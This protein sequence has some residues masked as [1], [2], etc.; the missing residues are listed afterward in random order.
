[1][2]NKRAV[3]LLAI[4]MCTLPTMA[5]V[6]RYKYRQGETVKILSQVE[7]DVYVNRV[8]S[9]HALI[10]NRV[11][12]EITHMEGTTATHNATFMVSENST[13]NTIEI[14][15][16][17]KEY[18]SVF[19]RD[20]LGHYT[21]DKSYFMPVVR[22]I[23]VFPE[24]DIQVGD[25]WTA[26]GHEAHDLR[27]GFNVPEP[28]IVPFAAQYTYVGTAEEDGK[29]LH[30]IDV[31][32]NI[33]FASPNLQE[34][35]R[36][37]TDVPATTMGYSHQRIY[38]DNERGNIAWYNEEFRILIE[39]AYGNTFDF[40]GTAYAEVDYLQEKASTKVA[41][42]QDTI[43][44]LGLENT[45]VR[46]DEEGLTISIENI[47]FMPD[48]AI[49]LD[50]EKAKLREIAKVIQQFPLNDLLISG[51]TALAGTER[52]RQS[53]SEERAHAVA[54]Y[55]A[56]IG[57]K[58]STHIFTRGFGATKPIAPNNTEEGKAKNRRVEI[59]ILDK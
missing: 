49:L 22:D 54:E 19:Q 48:S 32:Y 13:R 50:S 23:P 53:L 31:Q 35:L 3:L 29:T 58:D 21:I 4:L 42:V 41:E 7:E 17:G 30:V 27:D 40:I 39:T 20:E 59:T 57:A 10:T 34:A 43:A 2:K 12:A 9:H 26:S 46:S 56:E 37:N 28:F 47:Q 25:T 14:A 51:H 24:E 16:W 55:L 15:N 44:N 45:T 6:F 5:E 52:D 11:A 36:Y 18:T 8:F 1:M 33:Y 38:W